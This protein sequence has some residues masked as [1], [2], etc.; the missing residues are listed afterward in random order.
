VIAGTRQKVSND[1]WRA[2]EERIHR[3]GKEKKVTKLAWPQTSRPA[4]AMSAATT[5]EAISCTSTRPPTA[6]GQLR[7]VTV[8]AWNTQI[9]DLIKNSEVSEG[10][11]R[12]LPSAS[13]CNVDSDRYVSP[14]PNGPH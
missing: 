13:F 14:Y 11:R 7:L 6:D 12:H 3:S 2:K 1:I 9:K 10:C 8:D 5:V 4:T